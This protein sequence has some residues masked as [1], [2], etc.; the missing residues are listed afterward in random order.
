MPGTMT[1]DELH[2]PAAPDQLV[3]PTTPLLPPRTA[4]AG[5]EAVARPPARVPDEPG[6]FVVV[7][8]QAAWT[9][10][11][12]VARCRR[13]LGTRK[14]GH[15]GTLDPDATG[16]LIVGVG[17]ATRLLR[18]AS[19]LPKL[20]VGEVVLGTTTS[21]L[22]ASGEVTGRFEMDSVALESVREAARSL[23]GRILQVPPMVSAVKV[24]G[25]RL[26]ELAREGIEVD[27]PARPVEVF[28]F[29]AFETGESNCFR[30]LVKCSSG[31]YVRVL[32]ADLG[33]R[34][35]GGAHLRALRRLAVG[36]FSDAEA[37]ALEDVA[38]DRV[39]PPEELVRDM[40]GGLADNQVAQALVHGRTV[41]RHALGV[42]GDG[43]WAVVEQSGRLVA[44]CEPVGLE[45]VRP[46]VVTRSSDD[47][48]AGAGSAAD[49]E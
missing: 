3:E 48:P 44:I 25:R 24:A 35:G 6:G 49:Y 26:H 7:D 37:L 27:R 38:P 19:A 1:P 45:R 11:D 14:V 10:H 23:T 8:K 41:E 30:V 43:P 21:T 15:A 16:V 34:L 18:F 5:G 31:T 40:P 32:A 28:R 17:R 22:D 36:S 9:S 46:V 4:R 39:R 33:A 29:D 12:V 2:E 13:L 20:Y 42:V 47:S